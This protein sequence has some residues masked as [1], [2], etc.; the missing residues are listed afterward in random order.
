MKKESK[1]QELRTHDEVLSEIKAEPKL[2]Q[3][4]CQW[5][6]QYRNEF[7]EFMM[8]VRGVKMTYDPFFKHSFRESEQLAIFP[9]LSC[10]NMSV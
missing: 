3:E 2:Y 6:E 5:P 7:L 10:A 1:L 8:G 9:I 4:Y